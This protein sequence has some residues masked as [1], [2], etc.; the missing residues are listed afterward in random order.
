[1]VSGMKGGP[2]KQGAPKFYGS[3]TVGE[4]GQVVIP[5]EARRDFEMTPACKLLVFGSQGHG[6]IMLTKA[7]NVSR[8]IDM[9]SGMLARL[10]ALQKS[11]KEEGKT[12]GSN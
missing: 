11:F 8:L 10:E 1:M 7:E 9:A 6:G 5:A 3:T 12:N 2:F 4:R